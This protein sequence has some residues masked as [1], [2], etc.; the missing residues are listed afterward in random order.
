MPPSHTVAP[1]GFKPGG[2]DVTTTDIPVGTTVDPVPLDI[3]VPEAGTDVL[4]T[5]P[6]VSVGEP[7]G[8]I[9]FGPESGSGVD[10]GTE[11]DS[12]IK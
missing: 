9:L 3:G 6:G 7:T 12:M 5:E 10:F 2:E 8:D 11:T 1:E 4:P